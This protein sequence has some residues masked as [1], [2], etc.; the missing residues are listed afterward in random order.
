MSL[1]LYILT[2]IYSFHGN[3][4]TLENPALVTTV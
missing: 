1:P 3:Q 4:S 2:Y